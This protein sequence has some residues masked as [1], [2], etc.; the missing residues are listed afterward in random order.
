[1]K[2]RII[3]NLLII[4]TLLLI[5][6][7]ANAQNGLHINNVFSKYGHSK[8]CTMVEMNDIDI[9]GHR[10]DVFKTLTYKRYAEEIADLVEADRKQAKKIREVIHDG[11][12]QSGCLMMPPTRKGHNRFVV[13]TN[14]INGTGAVI[15]IEGKVT[16]DDIMKICYKRN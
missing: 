16:V 3:F 15:Y 13:F 12:V 10:I 14:P 11:K 8:G 5:S 6:G 2:L 9:R 4:A 7:N 1:M